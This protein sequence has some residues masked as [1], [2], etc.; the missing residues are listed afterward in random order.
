MKKRD[1]T[2]DDFTFS[3]ISSQEFKD[4]F[5]NEFCQA[6][7]QKK[8]GQPLLQKIL[9]KL[10]NYDEPFA[11]QLMET[12]ILN[13]YQGVTFSDTDVKYSNYL[14]AKQQISSNQQ[15]SLHGKTGKHTYIHEVA[16]HLTL[17]LSRQEDSGMQW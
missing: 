5:I 16:E 15:G 17:G 10:S 3:L 6:K 8:K 14:R 13:D 4:Y 11:I 1:Y 2:E 9:N 7:K 12:S